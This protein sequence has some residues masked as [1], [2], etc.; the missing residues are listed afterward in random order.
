MNELLLELKERLE[1]IGII[2]LKSVTEDF[3]LKKI[4]EKLKGLSSKAPVLNKLYELVNELL[5]G[6][7]SV[8]LYVGLVNLV[9]SILCTQGNSVVEGE[10]VEIQVLEHKEPIKYLSRLELNTVRNT[11]DGSSTGKWAS[12]MTAYKND[13]LIDY[14]L[15]EDFLKNIGDKY[16]YEDYDYRRPREERKTLSMVEIIT[17]YGKPIVSRL[18]KLFKTAQNYEKTN[19]V[20]I[21]GR[22][23][24][25]EYDAQLRKWIDEETAEDV[26]VQCLSALSSSE[27]N[28]K[29]LL[30]YSTK[31]KK[32][33]EARIMALAKIPEEEA[34]AEVKKKC[35]K[36]LNLF[37]M[38]FEQDDF[39]TEEEYLDLL[40]EKAKS[41]DKIEADQKTLNSGRKDYEFL[42]FLLRYIHR[43]K[44]DAIR[45]VLIELIETGIEE[46]FQSRE[47]S[48]SLFQMK[49]EESLAYLANLKDQQEGYYITISFVAALKLYSPERVYDEFAE[50]TTRQF[51]NVKINLRSLLEEIASKEDF[52][53]YNSA[54]ANCEDRDTCASSTFKAR[55]SKKQVE[56]A[57]N[58]TVILDVKALKWDKRWV[59]YAEQM[60]L[61]KLITYFTLTTMDEKNKEAVKIKYLKALDAFKAEVGEVEFYPNIA[62]KKRKQ[63]EETLKEILI[64]L[65]KTGGSSIVIEHIVYFSFYL[66]FLEQILFNY[67]EMEDM[68]LLDEV[69]RQTEAISNYRRE[70]IEKFIKEAKEIIYA[71]N[72]K[73]FGPLHGCQ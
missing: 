17:S 24:D 33:Q 22:L 31:K 62:D 38:V 21:M 68:P 42:T 35:F 19:I 12:L 27:E 16:V 5:E 65:L 7:I 29:F 2:G 72:G 8:Q 1:H 41:L 66:G 9:N 48:R 71:K 13:K 73:N 53:K 63:V 64:G 59:D 70:K 18:V 69:A 3:R 61:K 44:S 67:L 60:N 25:G 54:C 30:A 15:L 11:L 52:V 49:D 37:R 51:K 39:L 56:V 36:D 40:R 26:I 47:I 28:A 34:R 50:F 43:Y 20:R 45:E 57:P 6:N 58:E 32:I 46:R 14:R 4:R 23:N 55:D 10:T